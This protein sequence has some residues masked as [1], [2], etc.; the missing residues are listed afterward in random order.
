MAEQ[1]E[2]GNG[3][4]SDWPIVP[5]DVKHFDEYKETCVT[6]D[7]CPLSHKGM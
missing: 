4:P 7:D 6:D 3:P 1:R 2:I 5:V